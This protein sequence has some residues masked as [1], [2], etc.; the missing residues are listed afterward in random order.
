[1]QAAK[2]MPPSTLCRMA[3]STPKSN[4]GYRPKN[5]A[6]LVINQMSN[7]VGVSATWRMKLKYT[8][9]HANYSTPC[10][11]TPGCGPLHSG[12]D[13][14]TFLVTANQSLTKARANQFIAVMIPRQTCGSMRPCQESD[15]SYPVESLF[16]VADKS[17]IQVIQGQS[18]RIGQTFMSQDQI[19]LRILSRF[20]GKLQPVDI[21]RP[22]YSCGRSGDPKACRQPDFYNTSTHG[23]RSLR[24]VIK[25]NFS[26]WRNEYDQPVRFW[27]SD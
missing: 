17:P 3:P 25:E 20:H 9:S 23:G 4:S 2:Q 22:R 5:F 13:K 8:Q 6:N 10:H 14:R 7:L 27:N 26:G 16:F 19:D 15:D 21:I 11:V 18:M 1:M 12:P 24:A